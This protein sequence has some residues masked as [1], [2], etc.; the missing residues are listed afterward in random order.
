MPRMTLSFGYIGDAW[1]IVQR[2]RRILAF[3]A[4]V[5]MLGIV[6]S[7]IVVPLVLGMFGEPSNSGPAAATPT[8]PSAATPGAAEPTQPPATTSSSASGVEGLATGDGGVLAAAVSLLLL[9]VYLTLWNACIGAMMY[10]VVQ[11]ARDNDGE[12]TIANGF[13]ATLRVVPQLIGWSIVAAIVGSVVRAVAE[14]IRPDRMFSIGGFERRAAARALESGWS[15]YGMFALCYVVLEQ[16]GPLTAMRR[17]GE[18]VRSV[19]GRT[20]IGEFTYGLLSFLLALPG[21][22]LVGMA[23][24]TVVSKGATSAAVAFGIL[25]VSLIIAGVLFVETMRKAYFGILFAEGGSLANADAYRPHAGSGHET[26]VDRTLA[27]IEAQHQVQLDSV[28]GSGEFAPEFHVMAGAGEAAQTWTVNLP[29]NAGYELLVETDGVV[30]VAIGRWDSWRVN[31]MIAP[32]STAIPV[33]LEP[34]EW[35]IYCASQGEPIPVA[36]RLRRTSGRRAA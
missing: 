13:A 26:D 28:G 15:V 31:Q 10:C 3:P 24:W 5:L 4:V 27:R 29:T 2:R 35:T 20:V 25:G 18:L 16:D 33:A 30:Q 6:M 1:G 11:V 22:L 8:P 34:G 21:I 17:S 23:G 9:V 36:M 12:A 14:W 19:W 32:G 7:A